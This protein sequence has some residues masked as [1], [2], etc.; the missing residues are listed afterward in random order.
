MNVSLTPELEHFIDE[1]VDAGLYQ[2]SSE[3]VREALRLLKRQDDERM[4]QLRRTVRDGFAAIER[5]H[6]EKHDEKSTKSLANNIKERGRRRLSAAK[7]KN[8]Q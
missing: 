7:K 2:T 5:G 6:Y 8:S 3:V 4:Q 1:K